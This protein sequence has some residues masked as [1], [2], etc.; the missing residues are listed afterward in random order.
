[1]S[2]NLVGY[3]SFE[4][5]NVNRLIYLTATT[6]ILTTVITDAAADS[7][8]G[9][10]FLDNPHG[11]FITPLADEG[12]IAL[13]ALAGGAGVTTGGNTSLFDGIGIGCGLGVKLIGR[14]LLF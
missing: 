9:I 12:N 5:T 10:I 2:I 6:G 13:G 11:L 14:P 4:H 3:K 8:K 1:M 7:G